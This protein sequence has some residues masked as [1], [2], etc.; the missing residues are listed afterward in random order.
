MSKQR[1]VLQKE[2]AALQ[3]SSKGTILI[4]DDTPANLHLLSRMLTQRGHKA[5]AVNSGARAL[6]AI[7]ANHPDLILLDIMMPEMS[8][9]E[10]CEKLKADE[11]TRDI[12]IV[13]ISALDATENK[14]KA[15]TAGGVDYITKPFQIEEV[16][17]R[18]KAHLT[19]RNMQKQLQASNTELLARNSELDAFAHTVAHNLRNSLGIL[20]GYADWLVTDYDAMSKETLGDCARGIMQGA[21]KMSGII[22]SLLLLASTRKQDIE[23]QP[24][25]MGPIVAEAQGRLTKVI[26]EHQADVTSLPKKSWPVAL[27]YGSWVEEVWANYIGNAIKYGGQPPHIELGFDTVDGDPSPLIRF[28][29]RDNGPGLSP[30]EQARLFTPFERLHQTH[31]EGHGLG[32]SIVQRIVEKLGG[33][34]GVESQVGQGSVF[35]FALREAKGPGPA[36]PG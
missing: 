4:V 8:G 23:L 35:W 34:V 18:V 32:L 10:V 24:L 15:F 3:N 20:Y 21:E 2:P 5:R 33:Q 16:S 1:S 14:I 19:L 28:W 26:E 25:D 22:S 11:H 6:A 31:T 13:F 17:A 30:E 27:G 9:Y 12:P 7:E 29:V 36:C